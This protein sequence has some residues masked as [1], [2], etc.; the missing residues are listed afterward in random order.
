[1]KV[2]YMEQTLNLMAH[3]RAREVEKLIASGQVKQMQEGINYLIIED[4][5]STTH[6]EV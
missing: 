2:I 4:G 5:D 1:M 6:Q 3:G